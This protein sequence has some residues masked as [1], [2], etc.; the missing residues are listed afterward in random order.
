MPWC[1]T[2]TATTSGLCLQDPVSLSQQPAWLTLITLQCLVTLCTRCY[3]LTLLTCELAWLRWEHG[4]HW[5]MLWQVAVVW[6]WSLFSCEVKLTVTVAVN[7]KFSWLNRAVL[8]CSRWILWSS[9]VCRASWLVSVVG[10]SW[11]RLVP[12]WSH[13]WKNWYLARRVLGVKWCVDVSMVWCQDWWHWYC[14]A[15]SLSVCGL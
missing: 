8:W 4:T 7:F 2:V 13:V 5:L 3:I 14:W 10:H 12:T 15:L 1:D 6:L 11:A 9:V